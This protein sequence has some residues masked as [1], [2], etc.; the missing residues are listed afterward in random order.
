MQPKYKRPRA[1]YIAL[2][3]SARNPYLIIKNAGNTSCCKIARDD[4]SASAW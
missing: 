2:K 4:S 1:I 3:I